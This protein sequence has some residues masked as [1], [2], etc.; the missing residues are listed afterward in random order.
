MNQC[1]FFITFSY[2]R[3]IT[4]HEFFITSRRGV[5][6]LKAFWPVTDSGAVTGP[7]HF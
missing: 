3:S 5:R 1:E 6:E 2:L 7:M 4:N